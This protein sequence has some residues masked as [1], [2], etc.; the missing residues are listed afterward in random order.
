MDS[1][2]D[3]SSTQSQ[4]NRQKLAEPDNPAI[5]STVKAF[6]QSET[7][8]SDKSSADPA[9]TNAAE[10]RA[11]LEQLIN[12]KWLT[13]QE[14]PIPANVRSTW[15]G[16][17]VSVDPTGGVFRATL[18]AEDST[19][20]FQADFQLDDVLDSERDLVTIGSYFYVTVAVAKLAS[21]RPPSKFSEIRFRRITAASDSRND[22]L[23]EE[24]RASRSLL[25]LD[26]ED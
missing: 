18:Q 15:L 9:S 22:R 13:K 17:V 11:F 3:T 23:L 12:H 26:A 7:V 20:R 1:N 10:Q 19:T 2:R 6:L 14:L 16:R 8:T 21:Y 24:A 4:L 5:T 25:G